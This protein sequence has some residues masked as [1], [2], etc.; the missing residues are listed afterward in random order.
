MKKLIVIIFIVFGAFLTFSLYRT[1]A[2]DTSVVEETPS[3]T[4]L[5]YTFKIGN[6]SIKQITIDSGETKYYDVVLGNPNPA[7]IS[8]GVYYEMVS[9]STKPDNFSIEY[10]SKSTGESTGKVDK[11]GNITLNLVVT[12]TSSSTVTVKLGTVA[13]YVNGGDL[14]LSSNQEFIPKKKP[15]ISEYV[16]SLDDGTTG[17]DGSGVYKVHHDAIPAS[18]SATGEI[19]E[20]T[21]DYRYYG[22]SPNNYICLDNST[23]T[24]EDRYLY[25]IIGSMRED[26]DGT[27]KVKVVKATPLTDG[28][29]SEFSYDC[30]GSG[31]SAKLLAGEVATC[32]PTCDSSSSIWSNNSND[33]SLMQLLNG[34]WLNKKTG[35][36]FNNS[37]TSISIDFS[38]VGIGSNIKKFVNENSRYY[39]GGVS[40]YSSFTNNLY[41]DERTLNTSNNNKNSPY[42]DGA[43]GLIYTSDYGYASGNNC[44]GGIHLRDYYEKECYKNNWIYNS[45]SFWSISLCSSAVNGMITS[46]GQYVGYSCP[47]NPAKVYPTFYL[48]SNTLI[49]GGDGSLNNPYQ[50]TLE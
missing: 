17:D 9:P 5:E 30:K 47:N 20:A 25:R 19:I 36:I 4:D 39:L 23:G 32:D 31:S 29:T 1:F 12:N 40:S 42:W 28:T 37:S 7:K 14:E 27:Y 34:L 48:T 49:S 16:M 18:S 45:D 11:E 26:S 43:I 2:Y 35:T 38:N 50:I 13:G 3:T 41:I 44:S 8:Y 6:S 33:S 24:C 10:T 22:A 46:I 15:T 21:D